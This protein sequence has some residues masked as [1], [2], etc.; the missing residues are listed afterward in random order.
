MNRKLYAPE[1]I[2]IANLTINHT[3]APVTKSARLWNLRWQQSANDAEIEPKNPL[4]VRANNNNN[5]NFNLFVT[6]T[7]VRIIHT[8]NFWIIK[9]FQTK[10][11]PFVLVIALAPNRT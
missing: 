5:K 10:Q 7:C 1:T 11:A 6:C 2:N 9:E 4:S 8:I 3:Y